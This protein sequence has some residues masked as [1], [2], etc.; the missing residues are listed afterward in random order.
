MAR[1]VCL[2]LSSMLLAAPLQ[3]QVAKDRAPSPSPYHVTQE[4]APQRSFDIIDDT[5]DTNSSGK[6][7]RI[8]AGTEVMANTS[9]GFGMFGEKADPPEHTKSINRDYSVPKSRKAAF[10]VALRF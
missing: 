10:G 5:A 4:E 9:V 3:A 1:F 2:A 7:S 8:I 6:G